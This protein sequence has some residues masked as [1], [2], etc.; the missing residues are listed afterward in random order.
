VLVPSAKIK[1]LD[2]VFLKDF[3]EAFVASNLNRFELVIIP[4]LPGDSFDLIS[5]LG[6]LIEL[7]V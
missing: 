2:I 3:E 7:P 4:L 5:V 1:I 6:Q